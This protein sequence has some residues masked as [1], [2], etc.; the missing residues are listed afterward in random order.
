MP[1]ANCR[2]T[3]APKQADSSA[4]V[5]RSIKARSI[6]ELNYGKIPRTTRRSTPVLRV[7]FL[8]GFAISDRYCDNCAADRLAHHPSKKSDPSYFRPLSKTSKHSRTTTTEAAPSLNPYFGEG[9]SYTD[10]A[11]DRAIISH[12]NGTTEHAQ[13]R[14]SRAELFKNKEG[15]NPGQ[16]LRRASAV[17]MNDS[18]ERT[19]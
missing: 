7:D 2:Q 18:G 19:P 5:A 4:I 6:S 1:E 15:A 3:T 16:N 12:D 10:C 17:P 13:H 14:S 8:G 11:G 9:I